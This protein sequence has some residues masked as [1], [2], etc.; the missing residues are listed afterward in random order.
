[1][2]VPS[3]ILQSQE[4]L[5][6]PLT[7]R[8]LILA[9]IRDG[10]TVCMYT[11]VCVYVC[12]HTHSIA[13]IILLL[14]SNYCAYIY[15]YIHIP[16]YVCIYLLLASTTFIPLCTRPTS[17][18]HSETRHMHVLVC[19]PFTPCHCNKLDLVK[20]NWISITGHFYWN[21]YIRHSIGQCIPL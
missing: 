1:M 12:I 13:S 4:W 17:A 5:N 18:V 16:M 7:V 10:S 15:T 3:H 9:H 8:D 19:C 6:F 14:N 20:A 11:Y 21:A 2:Y